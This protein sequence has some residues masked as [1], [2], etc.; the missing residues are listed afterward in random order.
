MSFFYEFS[1]G[2][3]LLIYGFY[4]KVL[5]QKLCVKYVHLYLLPLQHVRHYYVLSLCDYVC[6]QLLLSF[7]S[8]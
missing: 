6:C 7:C 2:Y 5:I 3:E 1:A 8:C 4:V